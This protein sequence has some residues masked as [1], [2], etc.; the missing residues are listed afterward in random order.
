MERIDVAVV[1]GGPAGAT[2]A[3]LLTARGARVVLLEARPI[4][5]PK[6]CG[7]AL[8]P[9][10]LPYLPGAGAD[11]IVRRVERVELAGARVPSVH[12]HLPEAPVA[13]VE[14]APFD[15]ALVDAAANAGAEIRDGWPIQEVAFDDA[16]GV[17]LLGRRGEVR[18]DVVVG[19]DGD[20]SRIA[21]RLGFGQ[22]R[23]RSLA[24]EVD[25]PFAP[26][27]SED[28]LQLRFGVSGGYAWYFPKKDHANVGILSWRS[29][30]QAR[31][32]E[33]LR[34]YAGGIGLRFDERLVK[35]HWIPQGLRRGS[36]VRGR[37][38]LVGDAAATGDPFFGEGISYAMASAFLAADAI[39]AWADGR[40][41]L[42][43]YDASLQ[44]ALGPAMRRLV[45]VAEIADRLPSLSFVALRFNGWA[46]REAVGGVAGTG[47]PFLLAR[48]AATRAGEWT[49]TA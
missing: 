47:S 38:V 43:A 48:A 13:L 10:V 20:P 6:L 30:N 27:R 32:R 39:G 5:R 44:R 28:E 40:A 24:L 18:A 11:T 31:L 49:G 19:A 15:A 36:A 23:R 9:K 34:A 4:P 45:Y 46:R 21:Q 42:T 35:G 16:A 41:P 37:V 1:G 2:A 29:G 17:R 22:P 7:G 8:T 3:R 26:D 12:M 25:L 33:R 14:R